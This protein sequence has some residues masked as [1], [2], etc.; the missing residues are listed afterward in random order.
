[1]TRW[2]AELEALAG[3]TGAVL[4]LVGGAVRDLLSARAGEIAAEFESKAASGIGRV[5]LAWARKTA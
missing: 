4:Y 2:L 3:R 5:S 1:M